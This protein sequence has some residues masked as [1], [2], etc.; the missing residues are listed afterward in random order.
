MLS[1]C[2]FF[3]HP[4]LQVLESSCI[5]DEQIAMDIEILKVDNFELATEVC[6]CQ[7]DCFDILWRGIP[8]KLRAVII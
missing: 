4:R 6:R 7:L 5:D 2:K 8:G 1:R 3:N